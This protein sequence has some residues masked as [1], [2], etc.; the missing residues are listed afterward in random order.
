LIIFFAYGLA[1]KFFNLDTKNSH[2]KKTGYIIV[3]AIILV[4]YSIKLYNIYIYYK[5]ST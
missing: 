4:S 2:I 1:D 3:G 5:V